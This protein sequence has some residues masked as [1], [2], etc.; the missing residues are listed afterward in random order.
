M[1]GHVS[2]SREFQQTNSGI[3]RVEGCL[4][5]VAALDELPRRISHAPDLIYKQPTAPRGAWELAEIE[6]RRHLGTPMQ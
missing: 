5:E 2:L 3:G 4:S 6:D 1:G